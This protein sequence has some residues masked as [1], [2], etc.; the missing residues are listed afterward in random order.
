MKLKSAAVFFLLSACLFLLTGCPDENY[1]DYLP[2]VVFSL[3]PSEEEMDLSPDS[4]DRQNMAASFM[5]DFSRYESYSISVDI[6]AY[7]PQPGGYNL[8]KPADFVLVYDKDDESKTDV[9]GKELLCTAEG[10]SENRKIL[11]RFVIPLEGLEKMYYNVE[12]YVSAKG[13]DGRT[14][15]SYYCFQLDLSQSDN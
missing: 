14:Y 7:F 3:S 12:F 13:R 11:K 4:Y 2:G 9:R 8:R 1:D 10:E 6:F 15:Y 5:T